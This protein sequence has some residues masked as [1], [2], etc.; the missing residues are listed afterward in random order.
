MAALRTKFR[1]IFKRNARKRSWWMVVGLLCKPLPLFSVFFVIYTL[2]STWEFHKLDVTSL[3]CCVTSVLH[4]HTVLIFCCMRAQI[5]MTAIFWS[6]LDKCVVHTSWNY[7]TKYCSFSFNLFY[8]ICLP[9]KYSHSIHCIK[10][11]A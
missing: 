2:H 9:E 4:F 3:M 6:T 7:V 10:T 5:I 11:T 1:D 8:F